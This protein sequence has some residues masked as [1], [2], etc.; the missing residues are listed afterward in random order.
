MK[1]IYL[2]LILIC[3]ILN[4]GAIIPPEYTS[5]PLQQDPEVISGTLDN[6]L[7]YYIKQN[8]KPEKRLEL[9]LYINAGSIVE[10]DDQRGLAHFVEHMAFN[11]TK[12]FPRTEMVDYLTSIGM[13]YHNGLN[14]GTSYDYTVYEF[15]LP[16]D[17]ENKVRKGI[18]I[19]SDI[20]WQVSF[21]PSEIERERGVIQEE[22]R[23][24]QSAQQRIQDQID[25]V[26]F[27]G[28]RYA[29]R[30]PIGTIENIKTFKPE[31]LIR[32][33]QDWYRPDL[34]TVFI[35]GDCDPQK[36]ESLVKE[37]FGIIPKR[38][39]PRP[40]LSYP[41]PDNI[42][43]RAVTVLDKE[44]PYTMLRST[45]KVKTAPVTD[46]ISLYNEMKQD[47][48][49]T[50]V[51]SRLQELSQQ[52]D[53]SFSYAYMYNANWLQGFNAT[54]CIMIAN[55][56]RS[57][58]AFRTLITELARIRQYGYQSAELER[59]KQI[60]IRQ[61]EKWVADKPTM[62]S[63]DV[64]WELLNAV[65][66]GDTIISAEFYEQMLKGLINEIALSE[67]N[68]IVDDV[69][70]SE[71]LTLSLAG[72][73]KP[74]ANYPSQE[75]LL[76]IYHQAI[77]QELEP[78]EDITVNEPLL[79]TI[80]HP[81]KINKEKVFPK[82][83]IKQWKLSNGV[84][85]Y[86]KKTDFKADEVIL[87]AQSPGG[88]AK[89]KPEDYKA[90]EIMSQYFNVSGFGNFDAP[91]LQKALAGK[92]VYVYPTISTYYEGWRGSCSPQDLELM[93]QLLYQY[94]YAPR[95]NEEAF[96]T[97]VASTRAW[98][99]NRLLEPSNAFFD[100]LF[101]LMF[102]NHPLKRNLHP[103]ELDS[104][105]LKQVKDIFQE[106]FGDYTDFTFYV[107]GNFDEEQLK[108]YCQTY[109][110]NLPVKGRKEKMTDVGIRAFTGKK[111]ITFNKGTER[112]FVSNVTNNKASISPQNNVQQSALQMIAYE[113]LRE[114]VRENMS[115]AYVVE[116][117]SS[118]D[119][120]PEPGIF[121]FTWMGC[122]PERARE[123]NAA[124]F[125]T[126]DSLKN[127][128]FADKYIESTKT[129][130]HK[131]YEENIKS[132]RYWVNNMSENISHNLP[133]DC[134]LDY[135]ALYDKLNKK[136]ITKTAKQY[137]VFDK[138]LLS[139]YMFPE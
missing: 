39:N 25:K 68:D 19:L 46:L 70:T 32:Y 47:L 11:G 16:T 84:T 124:T 127:G 100:T 54:D 65:M 113:K 130:L 43:P 61:A 82:S 55:E 134:F 85:V 97:A 49:F 90:A 28:S 93:F 15:K 77:T 48:F 117:Q 99:Q 121:T 83:G 136:A 20:A 76:A 4:L 21:E 69:I 89:L 45:W 10:D 27:A 110:A 74:G 116:I 2:G 125:A 128:L 105:T 3:C 94:N 122:N 62:D 57:E 14:G 71:N 58:D 6:G 96:S 38:E 34:E 23:L 22:W 9:R 44:Q 33:Y 8:A 36:M 120:M 59:A 42:E 52:P 73:D 1:R 138:S 92:I 12:N 72:T 98:I 95:F 129:T 112:S 80:P 13:G 30:N 101:V 51:N 86:S 60:M 108:N 40:R 133:I 17:D 103:E 107:V 104:I 24:G 126:L 88:K 50:M 106:R 135:P 67:V 37:Y 81:G 109:L 5:Y 7:K 114:N 119:Y 53:P 91:A 75:E 66:S 87:V 56:G 137:Y 132:N 64:I 123:L 118:Y 35:V 102:N 139:V 115:G 79:E 63:E 78:W 31:S 29:E 111:E 131:K 18:S 26:R 41:V